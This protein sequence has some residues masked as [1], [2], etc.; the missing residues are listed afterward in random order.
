MQDPKLQIQMLHDRV[1]VAL[2]REDGERR[3]TGGIVIPATAA[4]GARR[5]A[6]II[7]LVAITGNLPA[8]LDRYGA[9]L[10]PADHAVRL[11]RLLWD[12]RIEDAKFKTFGC[13]SA[14]A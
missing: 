14:I 7:P 5:L 3:S 4:M 6:W 11:D 2:R 1:L 9:L 12:G 13:G 8:F 10:T